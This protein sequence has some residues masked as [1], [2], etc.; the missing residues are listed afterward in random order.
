MIFYATKIIVSLLIQFLKL[1]LSHINEI[2]VALL[3]RFRTSILIFTSF[4]FLSIVSFSQSA[5][6]QW[7]Y[8]INSA[9]AKGIASLNDNIFV[10]FENGLYQYDI[11]KNEGVLWSVTDY[12]SDVYISKIYTENY[13]NSCWIGYKNGNIDIINGNSI[14]NIPFLTM[15]DKLGDKAIVAFQSDMLFNY[16]AF[17]FGILKIDPFKKEIKDTY[18]PPLNGNKIK[19]ILVV[20]DSIYAISDSV[21]Y[22]ANLKSPLLA[23]E[24]NW[25][26]KVFSNN[27]LEKLHNQQNVIYI[28]TDKHAV[29]KYDLNKWITIKYNY[30]SAKTIHSHLNVIEGGGWALTDYSN[31]HFF[32]NDFLPTN[33]L[34]RY[35]GVTSPRP[36]LVLKNKNK[37]WIADVECG[38]VEW[39]DNYNNKV[40]SLNYLPNTSVFRVASFDS[41]IG[42]AAGTISKTGFQYNDKGVYVKQ[43]DSWKLFDRYNQSQW[44]NKLLFDIGS[45]AFNPKKKGEF[46]VGSNSFV[47]VSISY[48]GNRIDTIFIDSNSTLN[49]SVIGNG[50]TFVSDLS[51]DKNGNLWVVNP[52]TSNILNVYTA[53]KKWAKISTGSSTANTWASKIK[54]DNLGNKWIVFPGIGVVGINTGNTPD[55][56]LDD[57][58]RIINDGEGS[59]ALPTKDVNAVAIDF[60]N[61]LWV[62]TDEG[63][64]IVYNAPSLLTQETRPFTSQ[65]IKLKYEGNVEYLLGKTAISD[66]EID[67]GNRKWIAT[68]NAG[69]FLLSADGNQLIS[70]FTKENSGLISNNISDIQFNHQTGELFIITD[71]GL[72]S[73]RVDASEG[74]TDYESTRVF[75]N[76]YKPEHTRGITIQGIQF[77]SDVKVT[78]AAGNVVYKTTSNGGTAFWNAQDWN[79]NRV[80]PGVYFFWTAPN[81]IDGVGKKVGKVVVF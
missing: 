19:D 33:V 15:S 64:A 63:F 78:D 58:T 39:S 16:A 2:M 76:P 67:G 61:N 70:S 28:E 7:K 72:V 4:C 34:Y 21:L 30:A 37:Y 1:S 68:K 56:S 10:A 20:G 62:G 44:K 38:F 29:L 69:L 14:S 23:D 54:I 46:A 24:K 59:G 12:L 75:P 65:R 71:L 48:N 80:S 60:D 11:D 79:G 43:S 27:V 17:S 66:I 40:H 8:Y 26:S 13:T 74:K 35:D 55:N 25:K 53:N 47:P 49:R 5:I 50:F 32:D 77:D 41:Q 45:I 9:K 57:I 51:Y 22:T 73:Y 42:I 3:N 81:A 52:F 18:Y 36:N 6:H 31:I